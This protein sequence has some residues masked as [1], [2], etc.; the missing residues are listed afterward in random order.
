MSFVERT[1]SSSSGNVLVR[2][3][4]PYLAAGGEYRCRWTIH[5]PDRTRSLEAAGIDGIQALLLAMRTVHSE[6]IESDDYK[7]GTL[8]YLDQSDLD[9]P[10]TWGIGP[11]YDA[12][13]RPDE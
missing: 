9:L 4:A 7:A 2:F 8:S 12:G 10:P 13:P 3:A 11:L 5:W 6:L 1:F